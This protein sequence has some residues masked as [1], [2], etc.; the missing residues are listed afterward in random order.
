MS[1]L[2]LNTPFSNLV[3]F[4]RELKY[5]NPETF[6]FLRIPLI[7]PGHT[8]SPLPAHKLNGVPPCPIR[9]FQFSR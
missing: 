9:G 1:Q 6:T 3:H 7:S 5:S 2:G 8:N 4:L